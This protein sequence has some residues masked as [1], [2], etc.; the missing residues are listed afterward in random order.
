MGKT[1]KIRCQKGSN[2]TVEAERLPGGRARILGIPEAGKLNYGDVVIV[3]EARNE[4]R[5]PIAG[6]V[7]ERPFPNKIAIRYDRPCDRMAIIRELTE[8]NRDW[9]VDDPVPSEG[10]RPGFLLISYPANAD[11]H[12]VLAQAKASV[13]TARFSVASL[14][15]DEEDEDEDALLESLAAEADEDE[16]ED[17]EIEA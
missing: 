12:A 16:E 17:E 2:E 8:K 15:T 11:I 13:P 5:L 4:G 3:I 9:P 14:A 10:D 7:L 1:F 6:Q